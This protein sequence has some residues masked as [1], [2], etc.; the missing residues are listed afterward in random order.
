[1]KIIQLQSNTIEDEG[2]KKMLGLISEGIR[3]PDLQ[4]LNIYDN[5]G[6]SNFSQMQ[7]IIDEIQI[8][9]YYP[10]SLKIIFENCDA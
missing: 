4:I 2:I 6:C 9:E 8:S 5:P 10:K 7:S 3:T 1:L